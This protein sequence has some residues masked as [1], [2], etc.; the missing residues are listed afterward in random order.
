[1][2]TMRRTGYADV[3]RY[4]GNI[5]AL[6]GFLLSSF[7]GIRLYMLLGVI[8]DTVIAVM[9]MAAVSGG[10]LVL[11]KFMGKGLGL[12]LASGKCELCGVEFGRETCPECGRKFGYKC[13]HPEAPLSGYCVECMT[14]PICGVNIANAHCLVC[15][16]FIC[17]NCYDEASYTC[18]ECAAQGKAKKVRVR[19]KSTSTKKTSKE[20]EDAKVIVLEPTSFLSYRATELLRK[21]AKEDVVG[22]SVRVGDEVEALGSKFKVTATQPLGLVKIVYSTYL[23]MVNPEERKRVLEERKKGA[24]KCKLCDSVA[25]DRCRICNE[26]VCDRHRI[27]CHSCGFYVCADHFVREKNMCTRCA[28][29]TGTAEPAAV[30]AA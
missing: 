4:A 30:E 22:E 18:I 8:N 11:L 29:E 1:M 20:L 14:C 9:I 24:L 15:G 2:A 19:M 12:K 13:A 3:F 21:F 17:Q 10:L 26:P 7:I 28:G 6:V 16:K 27:F 5:L 25:V 23:N